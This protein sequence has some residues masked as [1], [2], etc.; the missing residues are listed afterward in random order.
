MTPKATPGPNSPAGRHDERERLGGVQSGVGNGALTPTQARPAIVPPSWGGPLNE[1]DYANLEASWITREIADAAMLRRVDEHQGREVIGQKGNRDCAGVLIPYYWPGEPYPFNYRLRRDNPDW[2][3]GKNGKPKQDRKYLGPPNSTNRL[4]VPPGVTREQLQDVASPIVIVEGE[5]KALALWRLAHYEIDRPRL[6]PIA[7]SGV[8]NWRGT[9]G[10]TGGPKGERLDVTGPIADLSRIEWTGRKAFIVFDTN[11]HTNDSV[12]WARKGI[13]REL[14]TRRAEVDFVNL[15]EDCGVNGIDDL[16]AKWGPARVLD[17][18]EAA[19]SGAKLR[20]VLPPQFKSTPEGMFRVTTQGERLSQVQLTTFRAAIITNIQLDDGVETIR[21]F[22]IE[23]EMLGRRV[24]FTIPASEFVNMNWPIERLGA[25]AITFP[26]QR[27]YTRTAIQSLSLTA[28]EKCI[29]MHTGW[30]NVDGRRVYLHA[31]GA[32]SAAGAVAGVNVRLLGPLSRYELRPPT[33]PSA[34][35]AAVKA[36]LRLVELGP[37]SISFPLLAA[38]CRAVFGEADFSLHLAGETGAFK[39]EVAA[40]HQQ[41]FGTAM[42]RL[43]LPG[44]WSSTGNALEALAFHAKDAL[45]VIDDFAPQGSGADV[46]RHHAAADRVFRAAGN[47]AGRGRLDSTAKLREPKP[48]RALILSTGEDIPRG[49]SVRARM[50]ILELPK[51]SINASDLTKCQREAECG[52]YAEAMGGFVQWLAGRYEELRACFDQ[53]VSEYRSRA[54]R[55]A[56]HARTPDIVANLQAG[57]ELY[58]EFSMESGALES[59]ERDRLADRC[60]EALRDAAAAQAKHQGETEPT[61]RFLAIL[62]SLLS[63]GRAHLAARNGGEPDRAPE[64]CGWRRDNSSSWMPVGECIGWVDGDELYLDPTA[65]YRVAQVAGRDMG[66]VLAVSEQTLKKRLHEK[67]LL[68][69]VD[70]KRQTLTV[71]RS[72]GGSSKDVLHLLRSTV[73]PEVSDGDE[74]AE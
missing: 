74:D 15:P 14:A 22:E 18:F 35:E 10:K 21:E 32:I 69:S 8:W 73:L 26:N 64:S 58:L 50:L 62:R 39:S 41:H 53:R 12:K 46:A 63:S 57:F 44:A 38:T 60:W 25:A 45:F 54:L 67:R 27:E 66:E 1:A 16:L 70:Q 49:Q 47:H 37:P 5:K 59:A 43:H 20:V 52:L 28:T 72:I 24:R 7:I 55:N 33:S 3:V 6:I 4:Y 65:A 48:P 68:A 42:N 17:L 51:G 11:V 34:L 2:T 61:A 30:R 31:G 13:C 36:S 56:A 29:Y 19:V 23:A 40:L 9:I 71:R